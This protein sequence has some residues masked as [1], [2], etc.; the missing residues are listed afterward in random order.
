MKN[1]YLIEDILE[2]RENT[3]EILDVHQNF[4]SLYD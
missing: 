3:A 4:I 2:L 1:L